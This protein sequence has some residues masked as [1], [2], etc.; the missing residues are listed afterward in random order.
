MKVVVNLYF[1]PYLY[2]KP[3]KLEEASTTGPAHPA[4]GGLPPVTR[5]RCAI[6]ISTML[7]RA[8]TTDVGDNT[9]LRSAWASPLTR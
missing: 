4:F 9:I 8:P 2:I 1:A 6:N 3:G 7:P 5:H